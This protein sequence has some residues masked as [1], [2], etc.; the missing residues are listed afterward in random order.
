MDGVR[1]SAFTCVGWQVTLCDAADVF[2]CDRRDKTLNYFNVM[3]RRRLKNDEDG[4]A[5]LEEGESSKKKS[6]KTDKSLVCSLVN[7]LLASFDVQ[8]FMG[9]IFI[10]NRYFWA[11]AYVQEWLHIFTLH[12]L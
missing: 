10:H 12:S 1:Q 2:G 11:L 7:V 8:L 3:L 6:S 5:E 4:A 9:Y